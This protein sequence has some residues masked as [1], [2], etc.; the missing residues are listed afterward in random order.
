ML[1]RGW[2]F[3]R[4]HP[5]PLPAKASLSLKRSRFVSAPEP[6]VLPIPLAG[7]C[8]RGEGGVSSG[9]LRNPWAASRVLPYL[10]EPSTLFLYESTVLNLHLCNGLLSAI[11]RC[12]RQCDRLAGVFGFLLCVEG[13]HPALPALPRRLPLQDHLATRLSCHRLKHNQLIRS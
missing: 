11:L 13:T 6:W 9:S 10:R 7:A 3:H 4:E 5:P 8:C 1:R 2:P 12:G